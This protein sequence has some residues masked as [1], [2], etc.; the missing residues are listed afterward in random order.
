[1]V[2]LLV[3]ATWALSHSYRG[4][5]H[6]AGLYTLQ[7]LA[8][9]HP[10][11]LAEDVFL[12]FGSQD[13]F[14]IFSPIYAAASRLLGV[15]W[16]GATLTLLLQWA[17][18]AAAWTLA[19]A[20]MPSSMTIFGVAV[21]IAMPGDY[22][23]DRIFTCIEPFL[24]PRMAA[25]ALVLG[26][27][28][29]ALWQRKTLAASL[30][31]AAV[32]IHP[33]MALAGACAL[34][35]LYLGKPKPLVTGAVAIVGLIAVAAA[36]FVVPPGEWGRFDTHWLAL[37]E[38]RSPYLFI[39]HWQLDDWS[40]AA[41]TLATLCV[42]FRVLRKPSARTL[43]LIALTT[44]LTGLALTFIACDLLH[45]VLLTQLQPWRWQWLGTVV[46]A[47]L[48][49]EI[50]RTLWQNEAPELRTTEQR[51]TALLLVSAWVFASNAYALFASTAGLAALVLLQ[52]LKPSE[53]RWVFLGAC[54]L[55]V[56][57]VAWRLGTNLE[58]T[59]AYYLDSNIPWWIRR[60]SSFMHD[61]TVPIAAVSLAFWLARMRR[62]RTAL[63]LL[64][65]LVGAGCVASFPQTWKSWTTREFPPQQLAGFS[66]FRERIPPGADVFWAESPVA[67]WVLLQRPSYLSVI[68]TSGM[69]FSRRSAL[70]LE[71]RANALGGA[72]SSGSFMSWNAG[73]ALTLSQQQLKQTC[74]TGA[75]EYLVTATD[76]G[77]APIA[78]VPSVSGPASKKIRLYHCPAAA[79]ATAVAQ[80]L[81]AAAT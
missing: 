21:L 32:L 55:G 28:A 51:T 78:E 63:L 27:L 3:V 40:R 24:T 76:L 75:F 74:D 62:G 57:A 66:G 77:V 54:G 12:R 56:I 11:S 45:L 42:G 2:G 4:I 68:Q 20:V 16:A 36:A 8:R 72:I 26:S 14:T 53:A 15:E 22:G 60:A 71:R 64:G 9:L 46:A 38:N 50:V 19:R 25:E 35:Y 81:A 1:M 39:A 23:P 33:I 67:V 34:V 17:L 49:P 37:V 5:F 43:S 69:V 48:L 58:F 65:G 44:V 18:L 29:A 59:D 6:D 80:T 30:G 41:V 13:G 70:E 10:D 52:R 73:T 31:I 61:G 79:S 47:L 7:A